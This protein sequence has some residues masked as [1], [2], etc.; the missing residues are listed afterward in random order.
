MIVL[1]KYMNWRERRSEKAFF[2][3]R[4]MEITETLAIERIEE[5]PVRPKIRYGLRAITIP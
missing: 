3:W 5:V 4:E 2:K 1:G